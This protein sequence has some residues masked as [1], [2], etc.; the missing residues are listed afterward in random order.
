[1]KIVLRKISLAIGLACAMAMPI[2]AKAAL[3]TS[4]DESQLATWLGHGSIQLSLLFGKVDG[5]TAAQFHSAVDGKGATF[6]IM[7]ASN[8]SGQ[9]WLIGGYNPQ[10]WNSSGTQN[11][12]VPEVDRVAFLFNLTTGTKY[13]Q[14]P[15]LDMPDD[16]G[17]V[18]TFNDPKHGPSFGF[19]YDLDLDNNLHTGTSS[20]ISYCSDAC[21]TAFT[22]LLDGSSNTALTVNRLEVYSISSVPEPE[23][24]QMLVAGV[25][26]V[27][28]ARRRKSL[29]A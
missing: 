15:V 22:S 29:R 25:A 26:V 9:T 23:L 20:L 2:V 17:A 10:S 13:T 12:T 1:M 3:L 4:S 5:D 6:S 7:E 14:L 24:W 19:G 8:A 11:I 21:N 27:G 16:Y 18:Q 28:L